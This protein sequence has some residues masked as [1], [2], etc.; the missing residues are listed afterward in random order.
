MG[1]PLCTKKFR[2]AQWSLFLVS[3]S[4]MAEKLLHLPK[5]NSAIC[6]VGRF[7]KSIIQ[8]YYNNFSENIH[9]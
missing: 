4:G 2:S 7:G 3:V 6:T 1:E 8:Q 5:I 9:L